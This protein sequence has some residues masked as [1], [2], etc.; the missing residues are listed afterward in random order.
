MPIDKSV[1]LSSIIGTTRQ[2]TS[3]YS[4]DGR[5]FTKEQFIEKVNALPDEQ[6]NR[7]V[8]GINNDLETG[9]LIKLRYDAIQKQTAGQVPVLTETGVSQE[10][11]QG[12]SQ[13]GLEVA[14]TGTQATIENEKP[15]ILSTVEETL[16]ALNTLPTEEKQTTLLPT[17]REEVPL[18]SNEKVA[19]EL[20]HQAIAVPEEERTAS[21]QSAV[22]A[23]EVSLKYT[24]R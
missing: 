6:L 7:V 21:Q 12:L 13:T 22:D 20:F 1:D 9:K 16:G 23:I 17:K 15:K 5:R 10:V 19:A 24:N 18:N 3:Q 11:P 14:A 2:G 4:I 8:L